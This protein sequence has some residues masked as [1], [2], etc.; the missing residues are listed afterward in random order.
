MTYKN[1]LTTPKGRFCEISDISNGDYFIMLKYLQGENYKKF[2]ECLNELILKDLPDF[3]D[4]DV[5][6]KCYVYL[7]YCMYSIRG[8]IGVVNPII[9]DQEIPLSLILNNIEQ[10]YIDCKIEDYRLNDNFTLQFGY[11]KSF[12]FDG[13][14]PIID[15]YSGLI[16]FNGKK[17]N[18]DE[19]KLLKEKLGT[20]QLSFIEDY[21]RQ[22]FTND[23]DIFHGIPMNK[24]VINL[25][26]ESLI[27]NIVGFY[28]Q[29]LQ[30]FYH[31]MYA[32]IK[33]LRM[34]YSDFMKIS[35]N[36]TSILLNFASEEN[37]K[38]EESSKDGN[39]GVIGRV[40]QNAD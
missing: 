37:K 12:S 36:E 29:P 27:A 24:M 23:C 16:G 28:K 6:E 4:F 19:K 34:S 2:Y 25:F 31:V 11:P 20:K 5:V 14:T 8:T 15:F 21:L 35:H 22:K 13:D 7:A 9:G 39:M 30:V 26:H 10:G 33:H 1:Y 3:N 18:E 40:L 17:L 38:I 32:M